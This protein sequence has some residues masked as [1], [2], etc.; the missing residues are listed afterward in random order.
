MAAERLI[1]V[2]VIAGAHGVRGQVRVRSFTAD[3][4]ALGA[5]GPLHDEA[6]KRRFGVTVTGTTKDGV[7]ARIE[8]VADRDAA[9]AL[10]G[11]RLYVARSALPPPVAEEFY[12]TDLIGLAAERADGTPLGRVVAVRNFGGDVLEIEPEPTGPALFVPFTRAAVPVVDIQG[13]RLVVESTAGLLEQLSG[14]PSFETAA[15][16]PPPDEKIEIQP[17]PEER[18]RGASRSMTRR[19]RAR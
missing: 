13:G 1:L 4:R 9:A 10:R 3:P 12:H 7:I 16:R 8:G 14:L 17:H 19:S 18:P 2:G 11:V 6:G 15:S 5:Y